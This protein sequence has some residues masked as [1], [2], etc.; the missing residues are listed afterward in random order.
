MGDQGEV[1][2]EGDDRYRYLMT[3][4]WSHPVETKEEGQKQ[5]DQINS[6]GQSSS[7]SFRNSARLI[8]KDGKPHIEQSFVMEEFYRYHDS[9]LF[10]TSF[11]EIWEMDLPS[12]ELLTSSISAE[13]DIGVEAFFDRIPM[14]I[15]TLG[16]NMLNATAGT[17]MQARGRRTANG[18]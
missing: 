2:A 4:S 7:R 8:E 6:V 3:N 11:E 5:V 14:A 16:W 18:C 17:Q 15:K 1:K 13:N 12:R 9:L 10:S